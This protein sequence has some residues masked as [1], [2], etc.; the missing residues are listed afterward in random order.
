[1]RILH[2]KPTLK[3]MSQGSRISFIRQFRMMSQDE[4]SDKLGITGEC[5]RRTMTRYE[6]GDRNP[7]EDRVKELSK[8]LNINYHAIKKY[9]FA[10]ANDIVYFLM[11]LEELIPNYV[12]DLTR[13]PKVND[14]NII[15]L[16]QLIE[17]WS[18]M[19]LKRIRKEITYQEYIE[20]KFHYFLN[21]EDL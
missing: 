3:D 21:E 9:D 19:R 1:M 5:K 20:W 2:T 4:V 13:I 8:I 15:M 7:K 12:I 17:T 14:N 11:W 6:K 18:S 16:K 10:S